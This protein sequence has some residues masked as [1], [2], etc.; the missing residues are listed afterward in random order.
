MDANKNMYNHFS[1]IARNYRQVRRT[2]EEVIAFIG[3]ALKDISSVRALDVGCGAG[4]YDLL[5]FRYLNDLHL[6]CIDINESMLKQL[7]E[8]LSG[9]G[10]TN[11]KIIKASADDIPLG[12]GSMDCIL[13]FN[14]VHHFNFV[15]FLQQCRKVMKED[16]CI[17]IYTRLRSQN[18][19]N[20]WGQHFPLFSQKETRLYE[21]DEMERWIRSVDPLR[22]ETVKV[23]K[24][25]RTATLPQLV[26]RARAK[27]YSTFSLYKEHELVEAMKT[28]QENIRREFQDTNKIEW[29][30][31]N[32]LLL[33]RAAK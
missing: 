16:G 24:F 32:I 21:L 13:T 15:K 14:A 1:R 33:I 3:R 5:L 11:V 25:K 9:H 23:F 26:E 30:D 19:R 10:I 8:Y 27:H 20:I 22:L 31:E 17:F 4:R 6:T 18:D 28:F 7:S 12:E 29:L 2:H